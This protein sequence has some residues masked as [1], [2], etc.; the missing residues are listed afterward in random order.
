MGGARPNHPPPDRRRRHS[1]F[2][3]SIQPLHITIVKNSESG[4]TTTSITRTPNHVVVP[5]T[6]VLYPHRPFDRLGTTQATYNRR[7]GPRADPRRA[8]VSR[9]DAHLARGQPS[10][11]L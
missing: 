5:I 4:M 9:R 10:P 3:V 1:S 7:D 11:G 8:R 6:T 2:H